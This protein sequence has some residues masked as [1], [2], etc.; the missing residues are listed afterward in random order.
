MSVFGSSSTVGTAG[1]AGAAS[2]SNAAPSRKRFR[3]DLEEVAEEE[4]VV[5]PAA[6]CPTTVEKSDFEQLKVLVERYR[7]DRYLKLLPMPGAVY[8]ALGLPQPGAA[9]LMDT[10]LNCLGKT[11]TEQYTTTEVEVRDLSK[12]LSASDF[13]AFY[14]GPSHPHMLPDGGIRVITAEPTASTP[15]IAS[16]SGTT[17]AIGFSGSAGAC[18]D[19]ANVVSDAVERPAAAGAMEDD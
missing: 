19:G 18:G 7:G 14:T 2:V 13:P 1:A 3:A 10:A 8:K 4:T 9:S 11:S 16:S 6:D 12:T 5:I 17:L 15:E